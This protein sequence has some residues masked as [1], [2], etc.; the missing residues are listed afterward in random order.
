MLPH[1][2]EDHLL[3]QM[4]RE[5][6]LIADLSALAEAES[7]PSSH[8][9]F[10]DH[11]GAAQA[12]TRQNMGLDPV[13]EDTAFIIAGQ[14][15]GLLTGPLYTFLKAVTAVALSLR[16]S[17]KRKSSV[18]PLFWVASEDHD[19]LE[20]NRVT[21]NGE[22]FVHPY[23]GEIKRGAVPPVSDIPLDAAREPLLEFLDRALPQTEFRPWILERVAT[24]DFADYG[25]AFTQLMRMLFEPF[26]L[27]LV[28]P[29]ALRTL[30]APV[31]AAL[32]ERWPEVIRA[33]DSG[34]AE[35][36]AAGFTPPLQ[37]PGFFQI[38]DKA[39]VPV[40]ITAKHVIFD[41]GAV[42]FKEAADRIRACPEEFS[43]GAALRPVLQ[44]A[45]LPVAATL[46]GPTEL[47]YLKQIRPLFAVIDATPS[48]LLPRISATFIE[49]KVQAVAEKAGWGLTELFD[50]PNLAAKPDLP[51]PDQRIDALEEKARAFLDALEGSIEGEAP[52]WFT[53]GRNTIAAAME[54]MTRRLREERDQGLGLNRKRRKKIEEALFPRGKPQER[55]IN[56][57]QFLNLYGLDFVRLCVENMDPLSSE[58]QVVYLDTQEKEI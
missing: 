4:A 46:A 16:L 27:R 39:R 51:V 49:R 6:T 36:R 17:K 12:I 18:K 44:D 22:R 38:K 26:D 25:S 31:L 8:S 20:V 56:V 57:L 43:P 58:H 30:T 11:S 33:F 45:S 21:L 1:F 41:S 28:H 7:L 19:V 40:T 37:A 2:G 10:L 52:K 53:K 32:V 48:L 24:M 23:E 5:E 15:P 34:T 3:A 55:A 14:Q 13:A 54:K 9:P 42:T 50:A 35:I 29:H 47:L